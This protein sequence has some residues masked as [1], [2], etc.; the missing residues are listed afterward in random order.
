MVG[1]VWG[2]LL[3]SCVCQIPYLEAGVKSISMTKVKDTGVWIK[4]LETSQSS[5]VV[6]LSDPLQLGFNYSHST[7]IRALWPWLF[8]ISSVCPFKVEKWLVDSHSWQAKLFIRL[9]LENLKN[10]ILR[11]EAQKFRDACPG[12]YQEYHWS[13]RSKSRRAFG[14]VRWVWGIRSTGREFWTP[15]TRTR[16]I[17]KH[18]TCKVIFAMQITDPIAKTVLFIANKNGLIVTRTSFQTK[19]W[20]YQN[21]ALTPPYPKM[22]DI[23]FPTMHLF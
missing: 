2:K 9:R 14:T 18:I 12:Y 13:I 10:F 3:Y 19:F 6:H 11:L 22:Q 17:E 23:R 5:I 16:F 20:W 15:T 21:P 7:S 4:V 1:K 8:P